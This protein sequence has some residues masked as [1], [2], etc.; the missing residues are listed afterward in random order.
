MTINCLETCRGEFLLTYIFAYS[1]FLFAL[2]YIVRRGLMYLAALSAT[3]Y[4]Q[5]NKNKTPTPIARQMNE[6]NSNYNDARRR[7]QIAR[8]TNA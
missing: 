2:L 3:V 8:T 5:L 6:P 7:T 1:A 4:V